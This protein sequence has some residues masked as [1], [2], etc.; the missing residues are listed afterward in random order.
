MAN[1]LVT[2]ARG[3]STNV[4]SAKTAGR[5]ILETDT[6][7]MYVDTS[8][9]ERVQIK[10][11]TKVLKDGDRLTGP[12]YFK[13]TS[14]TM[15]SYNSNYSGTKGF[16]GILTQDNVEV[17]VLWGVS[18]NSQLN[19]TAIGLSGNGLTVIGAG[20]N[21][22]QNILKNAYEQSGTSI[23]GNSTYITP[24]TEELILTTDDGISFFP[25]GETVSP[26]V[27]MSA[28]GVI[29]SS[30][31]TG[32]HLNAAA[33]KS[34][35]NATSSGFTML[36]TM[37]S[38]NGKF[39]LGS[40]GDSFK[41]HY[42]SN[43]SETNTPTK[44]VT[45]LNESGE[46]SFPGTVTVSTPTSGAHATTKA[47]VDDLFSGYHN[48]HRGEFGKTNQSAEISDTTANNWQK[49]AEGELTGNADINILFLV[50][51]NYTHANGLL[52]LGIRA[53][54]GV[55]QL[56]LTDPQGPRLEWI[57]R[58]T[59]INPQQYRL[60]IK[61]ETNGNTDTKALWY[62]ECEHH[63]RWYAVTFEVLE[64]SGN[65]GNSN[66]PDYTLY[67]NGLSV[68]TGGTVFPSD[69][70]IPLGGTWN[71]STLV[72]DNAKGIAIGQYG[73]CT[74]T[75]ATGIAIGGVSSNATAVTG[76]GAIGIG[77]VITAQGADSV[78]I[79]YRCTTSN[80]NAVSIGNSCLASGGNSV[81]MGYSN[82]AS[83]ANAF[84][85]G[86]EGT[87]SGYASSAIGYKPQATGPMSYAFGG[88]SQATGYGSVSLG[89][90]NI[91][92]SYGCCMV[93]RCGKID[94]ANTNGQN[95]TTGDVFV[96]GNGKF[97]ESGSS[98]VHEASNALR[99]TYASKMF[100]G[101]GGAYNGSGA[102]YAE[103]V[104]EWADGNLNHEDRVGY[105]VTIRNNKLE[106]A[107]IG[108]H[109]IGVTSGAPVIIGNSDEDYYWKYEKDDFNRI[110]YEDKIVTQEEID[111]STGETITATTTIKSP[112]LNENYDDTLTYIHR[113]NRPEWDYVGMRGIIPCRDDGTCI[114]GGFC[115]CG[116][117]GIATY[118]STQDFNTYY[119]IERISQ[120]VVSIEVK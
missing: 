2:F 77:R 36:A 66:T 75:S 83:G 29:N 104:K 111:E 10:D 38:T 3:L 45:L 108:D 22:F 93:G 112:K 20:E 91:N 101:S 113:E 100:L 4:P 102:D 71:S 117:N 116:G 14:S 52:S 42:R 56:T 11:D 59:D 79:G 69:D 6:G 90:Y 43:S 92:N 39:Y 110:I 41:L 85:A 15:P 51:D 21:G 30:V 1:E 34:I 40:Y 78:A 98:Y 37:N 106:K 28:N 84:I 97:Y 120:N 54:N 32:T 105:M 7:N 63:R 46:A 9:S 73:Y 35:I 67:T 118:S 86:R 47:Y 80:S 72:T 48:K 60:R 13:M 58:H 26:T 114:A 88:L 115:R 19:N 50:T 23:L 16:I 74:S 62:L 95:Q 89:C 68:A 103:F 25:G 87:A 55:A 94:T 33:G 53:S 65:A 27:R 109:I 70:V 5:I 57:S 18:Q 119:V 76:A 8:S 82:T 64:D 31:Q 81:S 17:P 107:E 99:L 61:Q 12:L 24:S 96:V 49:I 44:L